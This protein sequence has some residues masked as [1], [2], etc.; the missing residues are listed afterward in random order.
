M[1]QHIVEA[2]GRLSTALSKRDTYISEE[3]IARCCNPRTPTLRVSASSCEV[4]YL[5]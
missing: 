1:E 2:F 3:R 5:R 4:E